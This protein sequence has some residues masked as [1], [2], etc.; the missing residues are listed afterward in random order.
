VHCVAFPAEGIEYSHAYK[1]YKDKKEY[2]Q[3]K[4][5][6]FKF[7]GYSCHIRDTPCF[8]PP[9]SAG[10]VALI[11]RTAPYDKTDFAYFILLPRFRAPISVRVFILC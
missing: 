8:S 7:Q 5:D 11:I 9:S 3:R 1:R 10:T 4:T 6:D 2:G